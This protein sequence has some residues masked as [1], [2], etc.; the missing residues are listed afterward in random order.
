MN[1]YEVESKIKDLEA[2]YNK[3]ADNLMQEFNAYKKKNPILP[4]YGNDLNIDKMI[5]DKNRIIRSQCTRRVNKMRKL[6]EKFYDD[7][8]DIIA[9]EYNLS[10]DVAKLV[11]QQV[12]DLDIGHSELTS[13]LDHYAVFAKKVLDTEWLD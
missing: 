7:V 10:T 2:S 1:L 13:Y 3:E 5:A 11:V 12:R 8:T 6:W 4:L 9:A